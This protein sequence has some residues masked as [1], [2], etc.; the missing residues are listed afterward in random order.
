MEDILGLKEEKP[1]DFKSFIS[2]ILAVYEDSKFNRQ[3]DKVDKIRAGLKDSGIIL[4]DMK[5]GVDWAY[6]E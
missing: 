2:S 4:K 3:F 5:N 6:E 1:D